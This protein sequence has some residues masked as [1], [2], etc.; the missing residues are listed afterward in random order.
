MTAVAAVAAVAVGAVALPAAAADH[1]HP[2]ARAH[3]GTVYISGVQAHS[4]RDH[5]VRALDREWVS[6]TNNSR[7][8]ISLNGWTLSDRDGH[9]YRFR[10]YYL[11]GRSSVR[12]HTGVGHDTRTDLYQD[13]RR[14]VWDSVD[15]ATLRNEHGRIVDDASWGRRSHR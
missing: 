2:A 11:A 8:G 9:T 1:H 7:R 10:H 12:V 5:S 15:K 6:I 4:A 13:R 14:S 3:H